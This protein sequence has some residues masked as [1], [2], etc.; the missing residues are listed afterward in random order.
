MPFTEGKVRYGKIECKG[1]DT[2]FYTHRP[3]GKKDTYYSFFKEMNF[4]NVISCLMVTVVT[5]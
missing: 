3:R 5:Q 1:K 4:Q 2:V